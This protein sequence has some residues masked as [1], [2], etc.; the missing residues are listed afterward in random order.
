MGC[1]AGNAEGR[2]KY[3]NVVRTGHLEAEC[4]GKRMR[5]LTRLLVLSGLVLAA[6]LHA[7]PPVPA[8]VQAESA[9]HKYA[10]QKLD[11]A[12]RSEERRV[13]K[14]GRSRWSPHH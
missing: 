5:I 13:G 10:Q 12:I 4:Y 9:E 11:E 3:R 2:R 8:A 1:Q 6:S 7:Q 14:E